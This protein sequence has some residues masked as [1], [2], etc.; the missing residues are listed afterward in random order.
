[1]PVKGGPSRGQAV[2]RRGLSPQQAAPVESYR[3]GEPGLRGGCTG[4]ARGRCTMPTPGGSRAARALGLPRGPRPVPGGRGGGAE[5]GRQ[6]QTGNLVPAGDLRTRRPWL[7]ASGQ[8][9]P[10]APV[11]WGRL[12]GDS[13]VPAASGL[14]GTLASART[15]VSVLSIRPPPRGR[16]PPWHGVCPRHCF[17]T[18]K[19]L[20]CHA[21]AT[22]YHSMWLLTPELGG[23]HPPF[24]PPVRGRS[25]G[26]EAEKWEMAEP[27]TRA[28]PQRVLVGTRPPSGFF[29]LLW[30]RAFGPQTTGKG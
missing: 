6:Q 3:R 23:S 13:C 17:L 26:P 21:C 18:L 15:G 30:D 9:T 11:T 10:T 8:L 4:R 1:M 5:W 22:R 7:C 20:L 27:R 24:V 28:W 16:G 19:T 12:C 29:G 14:P 25:L 2:A